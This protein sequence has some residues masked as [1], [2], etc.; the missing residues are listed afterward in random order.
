MYKVNN[1]IT[2]NSKN[3]SKPNSVTNGFA[4]FDKSGVCKKVQYAS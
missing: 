4:S 3:Q 2:N 1:E